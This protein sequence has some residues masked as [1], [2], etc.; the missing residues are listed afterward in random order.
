MPELKYDGIKDVIKEM[1]ELGER[2]GEGAHR[3]LRVAAERMKF[4]WIEMIDRYKFIASGE[5]REKVGY[6][7]K[8][9]EVEDVLSID[10]SPQGKDSKPGVRNAE[11]AFI[12]HYGRSNMNATH[13]VDHIVSG[14]SDEIEQLMIKTWQEF[15]DEK[16]KG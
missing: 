1:V 14:S 12:L 9:K 8:P 10:V 15:L 2:T 13:F 11:K 6:P 7:R 3:M 4:E 5:M 16:M